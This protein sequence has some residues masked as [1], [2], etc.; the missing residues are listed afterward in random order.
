MEMSAEMAEMPPRAEARA[1]MVEMPSPLLAPGRLP[2]HCRGNPLHVKR[3]APRAGRAHAI[4][5]E[6]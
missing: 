6:C 1:E 3:L 4:T 5:R 2:L